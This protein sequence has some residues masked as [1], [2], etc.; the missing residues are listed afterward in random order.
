[1]SFSPRSVF[2]LPREL[3][4]CRLQSAAVTPLFSFDPFRRFRI[5]SRR[6]VCSTPGALSA[7]P[8]RVDVLRQRQAMR[9][10]EPTGPFGAHEAVHGATA[11]RPRSFRAHARAPVQPICHRQRGRRRRSRTFE[12]LVSGLVRRHRP[13]PSVSRA[14]KRASPPTR[15]DRVPETEHAGSPG[16]V[17][18][19]APAARGFCAIAECGSGHRAHGVPAR[20]RLHGATRAGDDIAE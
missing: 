12:Q 1:M 20:R 16:P 5:P 17:V 13:G 15:R 18:S 7:Y 14:G 4:H 8:A 10:L 2:S 3:G 11:A 9:Q 6:L 19:T